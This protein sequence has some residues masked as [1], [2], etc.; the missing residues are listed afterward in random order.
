MY[1]MSL[2]SKAPCLNCK[3]RASQVQLLWTCQH[4]YIR[5]EEQR[6][7]IENEAGRDLF[8][9]VQCP[10]PQD[11]VWHIGLCQ[12]EFVGVLLR[13]LAWQT[14]LTW[15]VLLCFSGVEVGHS[16]WSLWDSDNHPGCHL[17]KYQ[18]K[19]RLA[20][21]EDARPRLHSFCSGTRRSD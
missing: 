21:W 7:S 10:L 12:E 17:P 19:S 20:D 3:S 14:L 16:V 13:L 15:S 1:Q 4:G 2:L 11:P 9:N 6:H 5:E 18:K 8:L